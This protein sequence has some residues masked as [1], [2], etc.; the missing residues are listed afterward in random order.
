[1]K[2]KAIPTRYKGILFRSKLEATYAK[3]FDFIGLEWQFEIQGFKLS[4]GSCYLPD[5]YIPSADAWVEVKGGH[6]IG[7]EKL[8]LFAADLWKSSGAK[9]TYD[10]NSPMILKYVMPGYIEN[11]PKSPNPVSVYINGSVLPS[12]CPACSQ[13][14]FT[15]AWQGWCRGCK[16]DSPKETWIDNWLKIATKSSQFNFQDRVYNAN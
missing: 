8:E 5:F 12:I 16:K 13:V 2:I 15:C 6:N 1:M 14:T 3:Y 9:D 10:I 4:N 11:Y 7:L